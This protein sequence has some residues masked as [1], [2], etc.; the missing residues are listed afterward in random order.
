MS[1]SSQLARLWTRVIRSLAHMFTYYFSPKVPIRTFLFTFGLQ[2]QLSFWFQV[3]QAYSR[4]TSTPRHVS[5]GPVGIQ[6]RP[7]Y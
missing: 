1:L 4:Q 5:S 6:Q 3:Y 2:A 7:G